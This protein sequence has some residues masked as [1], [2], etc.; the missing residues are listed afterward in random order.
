MGE[1]VRALAVT[2]ILVAC[3]N[4]QYVAMTVSSSRTVAQLL[5]RSAFIHWRLAGSVAKQIQG[6]RRTSRCGLG[7]ELNLFK[8]LGGLTQC[9]VEQLTMKVAPPTAKHRVICSPL[10]LQN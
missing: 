10:R 9:N 8:E 7:F 2:T 4:L 3:S 1:R 5:V 6:H